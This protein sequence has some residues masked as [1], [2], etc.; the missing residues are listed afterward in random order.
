MTGSPTRESTSPA[1]RDRALIRE[2]KLALLSEIGARAVFDHL[3]R[4]ARDREL[5]AMAQGFNREGVDLVDTL[6][7]FLRQAGA[8]P[9]RTSLRRRA[10]ARGLV[11]LAPVLGSRR[12]LRI[13]R[14]AEQTVA[15]W[16]GHYALFLVQGGDPAW[17]ETFAELQGIKMRRADAMGAWVDNLARAHSRV[18]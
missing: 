2:V 1:A 14:D 17:A 18:I 16:Y 7:R 4:K 6:Q 11:A 15:R 10:L 9:R 12:V 5:A 8:K 13:I 3:D